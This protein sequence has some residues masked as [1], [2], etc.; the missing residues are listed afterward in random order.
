MTHHKAGH[1]NKKVKII[2]LLKLKRTF[3][4]QKIIHVSMCLRNGEKCDIFLF[5]EK[6][7][8]YNFKMKDFV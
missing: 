6:I 8:F 4:L 2:F 7:F 5:G 1:T 3:S